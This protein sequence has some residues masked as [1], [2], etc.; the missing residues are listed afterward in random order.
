MLKYLPIKRNFKQDV[1]KNYPLNTMISK[2]NLREVSLVAERLRIIL[3]FSKHKE[4]D[5]QMYGELIKYSNPGAVVKDMLFGVIP[6]PKL[7][8]VSKN[9]ENK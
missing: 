9:Q 7:S 6:L 1:L 2:S 3:E 8:D 5:L 4:R